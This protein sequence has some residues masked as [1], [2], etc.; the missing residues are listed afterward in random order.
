MAACAPLLWGLRLHLAVVMVCWVRLSPMPN[1]CFIVVNFSVAQ[2][3]SDLSLSAKKEVAM[4]PMPSA[5]SFESVLHTVR[6]AGEEACNRI[7]GTAEES[8]NPL[9]IGALYELV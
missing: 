8:F 5:A 2:F 3:H 6:S 1:H 9:P 7:P 4:E